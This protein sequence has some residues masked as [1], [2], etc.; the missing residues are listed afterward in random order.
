MLNAVIFS[1]KSLLDAPLE[2]VVPFT[3]PENILRKSIAIKATPFH[4]MKTT[5]SYNT[6]RFKT[7]FYPNF[8]YYQ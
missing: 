8:T 1:F 6:G 5:K 4:F 2:A 7:F 3:T